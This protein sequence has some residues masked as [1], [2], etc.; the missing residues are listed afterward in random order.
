MWLPWEYGLGLA[1]IFVL[2]GRVADAKHGT[3]AAF[4]REAAVV[5]ILYSLWQLAGQVSLLSIDE[6][7]AR[8]EWLWDFERRLHMPNELVLQ[9]WMIPH[10]LTTQAANIYY[11]GAHVPVMGIFLVWM[12]ARHRDR[13][14]PWRNALALTTG[15]CLIIQ[16]LPVAPPRLTD[17]TGM[18][19]TGLAYGQSVYGALGRGV[20]GQLQAMPSIHVA[21]AAIVGWGVAVESVNRWRWVG[22]AHFVITFIVVAVTGN[23]YWLDGMVAMVLLAAM[24]PLGRWIDEKLHPQT[25]MVDAV[26]VPTPIETS[27]S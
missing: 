21:W 27:L 7:V 24:V 20:A 13:Y 18:I 9:E 1:L 19:D 5:A 26:E 8:G 11:A 16:L 3:V 10:S 14:R 6:A 4:G 22:P 12:F 2:I 15:L 23:H 17:A 25:S